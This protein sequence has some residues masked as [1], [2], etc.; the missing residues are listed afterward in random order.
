MTSVDHLGK[1]GIV[2]HHFLFV[3]GNTNTKQI[4]L[5]SPLR[6]VIGIEV[7]SALIPRSEYTLEDGRNTFHFNYNGSDK[8]IELENADYN[9]TE[10]LNSIN[11]GLEDETIPIV[12]YEDEDAK[13]VCASGTG[14]TFSIYGNYGLNKMLG[15]HE[16]IHA[17]FSVNGSARTSTMEK[18]NNIAT[19]PTN[20]NTLFSLNTIDNINYDQPL[21]VQIYY[22]TSYDNISYMT[23]K[24][25]ALS[26]NGLYSTTLELKEPNYYFNTDFQYS[27][28]L[29]SD[30]YDKTLLSFPAAIDVDNIA[31]D[32]N[33]SINPYVYVSGKLMLF[34]TEPWFADYDWL[35]D[36]YNYRD[37]I[38]V[39]IRNNKQEA[40]TNYNQDSANNMFQ[41]LHGDVILG[42]V[43]I[44]QLS[45]MYDYIVGGS[46]NTAGSGS[47][48]PCGPVS[49]VP[50]ETPVAFPSSGPAILCGDRYNLDGTDVILLRSNIDSFINGGK[51]NQYSSPLAKF[52][53]HNKESQLV[54]VINYEQPARTFFPISK[55]QDIEFT[56]ERACI[57][58][59]E[60]KLYQFHHLQW[61]MQLVVKTIDYTPIP[62]EHPAKPQEPVFISKRIIEEEEN[63]NM[64][65]KKQKRL[66]K[67]SNTT[68]MILYALAGSTI[69]YVAYRRMKRN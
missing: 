14:N 17:D 35:N 8:Q 15:F 45:L 22:T 24:P 62:K 66:R 47:C 63:D 6:N 53:V 43:R 2:S 59:S 44:Q 30:E 38:D 1:H 13:R 51:Y 42:T 19:E 37:I 69:A 57:D 68:N 52:Y 48:G 9:L 11:Y 36:E 7:N 12:L 5:D 56:F 67:L 32:T 49:I 25:T 65:L 40:L 60:H 21:G 33:V 34:I 39:Y 31:I 28:S 46:V 3:C 16:T 58:Q 54:Q 61:Y 23:F 50:E 10:L 26:G 29:Y 27:G 41:V 4:T 18:V 55:L 64:A 20:Y